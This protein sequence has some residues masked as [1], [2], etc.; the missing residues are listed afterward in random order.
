MI[1]KNKKRFCKKAFIL[2][3]KIKKCIRCKWY[4]KHTKEQKKILLDI[5]FMP[6]EL[7]DFLLLDNFLNKKEYLKSIQS[8]LDLESKTFNIKYPLLYK[9]GN[10]NVITRKLYIEHDYAEL[11]LKLGINNF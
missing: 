4:K 6:E 2:C 10:M 7:I 3:K 1:N 9:I 11:K 8:F 5:A